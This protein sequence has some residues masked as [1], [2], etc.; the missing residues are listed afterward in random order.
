MTSSFSLSLQHYVSLND[1]ITSVETIDK[2]RKDRTNGTTAIMRFF[3]RFVRI[4]GRK[5][6][7]HREITGRKIGHGISSRFLYLSYRD[8]LS[9]KAENYRHRDKLWEIL[10]ATPRAYK[11]EIEI[12]DTFS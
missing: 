1:R 4:R 5:E 12:R 6:K 2:E 11:D 9:Q 8:V 7:E 10:N 3:V